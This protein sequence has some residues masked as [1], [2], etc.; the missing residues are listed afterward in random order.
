M[1]YFVI[2]CE[3]VFHFKKVS[4]TD[5]TQSDLSFTY[6]DRF[7]ATFWSCL[8]FCDVTM[9]FVS[10]STKILV[11]YLWKLASLY[12]SLLPSI[13]GKHLS[14]CSYFSFIFFALAF[15][16]HYFYSN[17]SFVLFF[18]LSS[19]FTCFTLQTVLC[20]LVSITVRVSVLLML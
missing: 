7:V 5:G 14:T 4:L 18:S 19:V 15:T 17:G 20:S 1:P 6:G 8:C 12:S 2:F 13:N 9:A 3:T 11:L 16:F 10:S